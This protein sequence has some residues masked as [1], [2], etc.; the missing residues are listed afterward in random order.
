MRV[1]VLFLLVAASFFLLV[2]FYPSTEVEGAEEEPAAEAAVPAEGPA[3]GFL[4]RERVPAPAPRPVA[5][6][7]EEPAKSTPK[8]A[9]PGASWLASV[10]PPAPKRPGE[11]AVASTLVHG[12]LD[13]VRS[14]LGAAE[15][16]PQ[17]QRDLV[18][19]FARAYEGDPRGGFD[20][21]SRIDGAALT[22]REKELLQAVLSEDAG[23][24]SWLEDGTPESTTVLAMEMLLESRRATRLLEAGRAPEA[25]R[26]FS[27]LILTELDAPW[28]ASH[29]LLGGWSE[30]LDRAQARNRWHPKGDW[31]GEEI[32]VQPGDNAIAIRKRYLARHPDRIMCAGLI[33]RA[34]AIHGYLQPGQVLRIPTDPVDVL[35]DL[36]DR[37]AVYR[38]GGEVAGSWPVG[39]GRPGEETPPGRYTVGNKLTNPPWMRAGQETIPFGDPRNPLGTRWLGWFMD[40]VRTSYGFHGTKD[41]DS[42]GKPS[43]DGCIRFRNEDVEELFEIL[44]EGA[45]I[46]VREH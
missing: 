43:S 26:A 3:T 6:G 25:A 21:A 41:P 27:R 22:A 45:P 36:E 37:W 39:I 29:A 1:L 38:I 30:S 31:P 40:G 12:R 44:P 19:S 10:E 46:L 32:T 8:E 33:L 17:A 13:D 18:E 24:S 20:Q 35:V 4:E 16:Y 23:E 11:I 42:V 5:A 9:A 34:N 28:P 7:A 15:G 2:R 14:A